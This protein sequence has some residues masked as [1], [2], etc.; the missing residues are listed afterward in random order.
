[1]T[2]AK[3]PIPVLTPPGENSDTIGGVTGQLSL[4]ITTMNVEKIIIS[5][6]H[7]GGAKKV[8]KLSAVSGKHLCSVLNNSIEY[9]VKDIFIEYKS[10][11]LI[12][13]NQQKSTQGLWPE[14]PIE[15]T[16]QGKTAGKNPQYINLCVLCS[17]D[18]DGTRKTEETNSPNQLL[19]KISKKIPVKSTKF[20]GAPLQINTDLKHLLPNRTTPYYRYTGVDLMDAN[21]KAEIIVF[22]DI[23]ELSSS[24]VSMLKER[25]ENFN[26]GRLKMVKDIVGMYVYYII[27]S[28]VSDYNGDS[29]YYRCYNNNKK[30]EDSTCDSY[31]KLDQEIKKYTQQKMID[32]TS[33]SMGEVF[34]NQLGYKSDQI[35]YT[36]VGLF[37]CIVLIIIAYTLISS[38][39]TNIQK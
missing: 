36:I 7:S 13:L 22:P 26:T 16:F 5:R 31:L 30:N 37:L 24:I 11:H 1:M 14:M 2:K 35:I 6:R 19:L 28:H 20:T 3:P 9:I 21:K 12:K 15:I 4:K 18:E 39:S 27:D 17:G 10:R 34:Y 33:K 23:I 38:I 29:K 8:I 25:T 32:N